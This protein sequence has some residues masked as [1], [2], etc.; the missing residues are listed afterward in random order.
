M[1]TFPKKWNRRES[2]TAAPSMQRV[3]LILR[4]QAWEVESYTRTH[5]GDTVETAIANFTY[6]SSKN[7]AFVGERVEST[8]ISDGWILTNA[9]RNLVTATKTFLRARPNVNPQPRWVTSQLLTKRIKFTS[10]HPIEE[11]TAS[12]PKTQQVVSLA[13]FD[14]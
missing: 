8:S 10:F 2:R 1:V 3:H 6:W 14:I 4:S 12:E 7:C 13:I 9:P 11:R 5:V